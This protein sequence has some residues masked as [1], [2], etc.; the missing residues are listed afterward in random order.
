MHCFIHALPITL[1]FARQPCLLPC[2]IQQL[3][4]SCVSGG[5]GASL[6]VDF[7][8]SSPPPAPSP[9]CFIWTAWWGAPQRKHTFSSAQFALTSALTGI[10]IL[11]GNC[12]RM[13][14]NTPER[15]A[16]FQHLNKQSP[17]VCTLFPILLG[18]FK[19]ACITG[20][21]TQC[22][23]WC[24]LK[25]YTMHLTKHQILLP[26]FSITSRHNYFNG[27]VASKY[28]PCYQFQI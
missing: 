25:K 16:K 8:P 21:N 9:P 2:E 4:V 6:R 5:R 19:S 7:C 13:T 14:P 24:P 15:S 20:Q 26:Y 27:T 17:R 1:L 11:V 10:F 28:V 22:P 23:S 3:T 18:T 12:S